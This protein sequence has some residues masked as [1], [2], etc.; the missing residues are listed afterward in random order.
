[1]TLHRAL[2]IGSSGGIGSAIS[3]HLRQQGTHVTALSRSHDGLDI[4]DE[5]SVADCLGALEASYDLIFV[6]TGALQGAGRLPEKTLR[7]VSPVALMDQFR[8][9]ALGPMMVL[10]HAK[11]LLPRQSRA[12]FAVLSARVGSIGDNQL[13]GWY[14]Y[15]A[16]KAALNQLIH[17]SAIELAR[18]HPQLACV[19]L[20]PGTVQTEFTKDYQSRHATVSPQAAASN[21]ISVIEGLSPADTGGFFDW[22][23][24]PV[25]W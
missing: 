3:Q 6:T 12:T 18:T 9:N 23:G 13:G 21:L 5:T 19:A 10:K 17:T 2:I 15:R 24:K 7:A 1:M 25:P 22:A 20:H 4:T 16:A 14:S 11:R 8:V